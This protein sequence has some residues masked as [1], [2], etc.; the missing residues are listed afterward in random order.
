[1]RT[2]LTCLALAPCSRVLHVACTRPGCDDPRP[3]Q[4]LLACPAD[5]CHCA[6]CMP[7]TRLLHAHARMHARARNARA[8]HN[9]NA[10][11]LACARVRR[12]VMIELGM[13]CD[14]G[15]DSLSMAATAGG[16]VRA[17]AVAHK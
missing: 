13:A 3:K 9:A 10:C 5:L 6:V 17:L 8:R 14:G 11:P 12:D 1:M 16:E 4:A 15:K 7:A 2:A